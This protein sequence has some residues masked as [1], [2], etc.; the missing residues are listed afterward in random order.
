[1]AGRSRRPAQHSPDSTNTTA[2][3][4]PASPQSAPPETPAS[5]GLG[6][7]LLRLYWM[8]LGNLGLVI[9]ALLAG[10][11]PAPSP[12]D[13]VYVAIVI[14]VIVAR[15]L[16]ISRFGGGTVD[17]DPA[18]MGHWRRHALGLVPVAVALWLG[19]RFLHAQGWF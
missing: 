5:E 11:R 2:G 12:L 1:M 4:Q 10:R 6:G 3:V 7:C 17:G 16:D 19:A 14:S 13:G 15:Y 18:T 9:C 8:G